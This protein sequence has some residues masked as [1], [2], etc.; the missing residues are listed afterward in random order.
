MAQDFIRDHE[1]LEHIDT[2]FKQ[3]QKH[4]NVYKCD[5]TE[6]HEEFKKETNSI[7]KIIEDLDVEYG[8]KNMKLSTELLTFKNS[9]NTFLEKNTQDLA[10]LT[11]RKDYNN[12][13]N[14]L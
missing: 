4:F 1:K 8:R 2:I 5:T 13:V 11:P 9:Y 14:Q 10:K 3:F 12:L 7:K 6:M